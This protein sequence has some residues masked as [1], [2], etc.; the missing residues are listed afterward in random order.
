MAKVIW[1]KVAKDDLQQIY[2]YIS[3]DSKYYANQVKDYW[4]N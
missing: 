3:R 1:S 4:K 2:K